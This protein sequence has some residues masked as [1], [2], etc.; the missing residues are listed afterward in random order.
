MQLYEIGRVEKENGL[1]CI[2]LQKEFVSALTN[3]NGF[4]HL[5][6]VWWGSLYDNQEARKILITEKPYKKGPEKLG[7]FAT[8]SPVRPN[9][10]LI[11]TI[12]VTK[13]DFEKGVIYTP[14]IDA[15]PGTPV[16]DI[17]PYHKSSRIKNLNVPDWCKHWPEWY[18]DN[19]H[20][21]W[22]NEFNF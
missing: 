3:I 1:F 11:T 16:L 6:I 12:F 19:E 13:I 14:Y 20:F 18:E 22:E 8:R 10:I 5:D 9:P 15:E 7:I 17:K 21:D 2:K 4:S